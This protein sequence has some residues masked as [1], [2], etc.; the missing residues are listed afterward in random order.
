MEERQNA[1][2]IIESIGGGPAIKILRNCKST[3]KEIARIAY[4]ALV[5]M[6]SAKRDCCIEEIPTAYL[7]KD[8]S[9]LVLIP[10]GTFL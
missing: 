1:I 10:A 4:A 2:R 5:Q 8:G 9:E 7:G 3:D 6:Q